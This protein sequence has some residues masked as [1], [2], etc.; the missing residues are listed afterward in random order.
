MIDLKNVPKTIYLQVSDDEEGGDF[1]DEM[2]R[3]WCVDMINENDIEYT[4]S[5]DVEGLIERLEANLQEA[6]ERPPRADCYVLGMR[7]AIEAIH[8]HLNQEGE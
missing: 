7:T 2:E 6:L 8:K 1:Y 3:T 4:R 5:V